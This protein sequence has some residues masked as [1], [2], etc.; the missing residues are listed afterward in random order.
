MNGIDSRKAEIQKVLVKSRQ[1]FSKSQETERRSGEA[2]HS[3]D[4]AYWEGYTEALEW[5][6]ELMEEQ[7]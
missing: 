2:I 7:R 1:A 6:V 5:V 4:R 3:L